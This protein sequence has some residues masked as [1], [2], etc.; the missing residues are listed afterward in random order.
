MEVAILDGQPIEVRLH[1]ELVHAVLDLQE[2]QEGVVQVALRRVAHEEDPPP[3][4][5][6]GD[7]ALRR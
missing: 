2:V 7:D 1:L 5:S 4:Q 3:G 6:L